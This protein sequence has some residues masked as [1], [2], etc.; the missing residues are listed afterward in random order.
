MDPSCTEETPGSRSASWWTG[1]RR[2]LAGRPSAEGTQQTAAPGQEQVASIEAL[3][4]TS[5]HL[6]EAATSLGGLAGR[7]RIHRR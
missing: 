7:F 4:A 6:A 3:A 2:G 1:A 5:Q